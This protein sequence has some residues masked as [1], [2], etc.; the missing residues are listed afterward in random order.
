MLAPGKRLRPLLTVMAAEACG[1]GEADP[2]PA[3]C[4]VELIHAYSLIHDDLP[5]MDDDD[6]RAG[7]RP[8]TRNLARLWLSWPEMLCRHWHSSCWQKATLH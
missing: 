3:G 4:A 6:L 2:V 1:G 8:V 5:A 7:S